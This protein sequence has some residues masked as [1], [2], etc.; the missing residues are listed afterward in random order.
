MKKIVSLLLA[1]ALVLLILLTACGADTDNNNGNNNANPSTNPPSTQNGGDATLSNSDNQQGQGQETAPP[2]SGNQLGIEN[3]IPMNQAI[4]VP[5]LNNRGSA[6][7]HTATISLNEVYRGDEALELINDRIREAGR[8]LMAA[9][10]TDDDYEFL[11]AQ[12]TFTLDYLFDE[13]MIISTPLTMIAFSETLEQYPTLIA[14]HFFNDYFPRLNNMEVDV[15]ETVIGY[16]VFQVRRD[17]ARPVVSY[18][19]RLADLS[20]GAWFRL[21]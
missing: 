8:M 12:F 14:S 15:G 9:P 10:P 2:D 1:F 3:L 13:D 16:A 18:G 21:Y 19:N 7:T 6:H 11:A 5:V 20:D 17:D 4:T